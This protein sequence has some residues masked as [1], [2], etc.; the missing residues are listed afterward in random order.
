MLHPEQIKKI[1]QD[2]NL[3]T[4][5]D[6]SGVNY[7]TLYNF[8]KGKTAQPSYYLIEKLSNYLESNQ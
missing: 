6:K 5:S 3:S 7:R 2:R 8:A 4:V 1:L